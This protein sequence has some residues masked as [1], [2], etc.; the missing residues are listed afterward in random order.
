MVHST[1]RLAVV[2]DDY[3]FS[4]PP[5]SLLCSALP[6][7]CIIN[8][9]TK[10]RHL[11]LRLKVLCLS[12]LHFAHSGYREELSMLNPLHVPTSIFFFQTCQYCPEANIKDFEALRDLDSCLSSLTFWLSVPN[13]NPS[14]P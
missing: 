11:G 7:M 5:V 8:A 2:N 3:C 4:P 9:I 14:E 1:D 10:A 13:Y 12:F 6:V